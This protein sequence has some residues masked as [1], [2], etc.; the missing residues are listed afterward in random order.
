VRGLAS[1]I[2]AFGELV[3]RG[4]L[5]H[6]FAMAA[7][8][9][10]RRARVRRRPEKAARVLGWAHAHDPEISI[11]GLQFAIALRESGRS[12]EAVDVLQDLA[13][14]L[15]PNDPQTLGMAGVE[16][17]ALGMREEA[18]AAADELGKDPERVAWAALIQAALGDVGAVR[19][20]V[21]SAGELTPELWI[22]RPQLAAALERAG[23]PSRALELVRDKNPA[24]ADRLNATIRTYDPAWLPRLPER[25]TWEPGGDRILYLLESS[26]PYTP[27]GYGYRSREL[28][29]ALRESGL[30]P[31]VATRMGFPSSR[32]IM[33]A[34]VEET[35]DGVIHHRLNLPGVS[36]YT[37]IPLDDRMQ[38]NAEWLLELV[39]QIRPAAI[40]AATP[41]FN[42]LLAL[43]LR[44]ATG[45]PVIYDVRGFPEMTWATRP[46][47]AESEVYWRRREAETR[48]AAEANG[49]ITTSG[50]MRDELASR[51][52]GPDA[53]RIVPQIV[54]LEAYSPL[55]R[56]PDLARSYGLEGSF[57]V[58]TISSL[59]E[60][61]GFDAL[62][63]A[64]ALARA[65]GRDVAA[66]VGGDGAARPALEALAV[67]LEL[68]NAAVFAGRIEHEQVPAHYALLD[69]FALP[70]R[71][72]E[73]CRAVTPLKPF[74][75]LAT[76]TPILVSDL[77]ALAEIVTSS[78]GGRIVQ[79]DSPEALAAAILELEGDPG[80]RDRLAA[81]AVEYAVATNDRAR[82]AE[83]LRAA[84]EAVSTLTPS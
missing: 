74:E 38:Q 27:S 7:Y 54:D 84:F 43:S 45:T 83:A 51:G 58:G 11:Y 65:E 13:G 32:G 53:T 79:P 34:P 60:Y 56:D 42:G 37:G 67:E 52:V 2:G 1:K 24:A 78:G 18:V 31:E 21:A 55:P 48:C 70:R 57:V 40:I 14:R 61:E 19:E 47:G 82:A 46:G 25:R 16:M 44:E 59:V 50:T 75:A 72:L 33:G 68:G 66:F 17:A 69:L 12:H 80:E 8:V 4:G 62:L 63:R 39:D 71:D 73:V 81:A 64:V 15:S 10:G 35:V 23:E 49:V 28:L 30:R 36:K 77:P 9:R 22:G 26:L 20:L 41:H 6:P 3:R 29:R 5:R 76:G